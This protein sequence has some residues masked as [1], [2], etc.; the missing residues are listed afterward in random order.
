[1]A[2][3]LLSLP[4]ATPL[5]N[6]S[7]L[8]YSNI[9]ASVGLALAYYVLAR[10]GLQFQLAGSHATPVW[11][12]SG[13]ALAAILL[14]DS[15]SEDTLRHLH[16]FLKARDTLAPALP[17]QVLLSADGAEN[18]ESKASADPATIGKALG[19]PASDVSSG[20]I[21]DQ[22]LRL[23]LLDRLLQQARVVD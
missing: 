16:A 9:G 4:F 14:M 22:T 12:P 3:P 15:A 21:Q 7:H 5:R 17:V 11:P 8:V 10:I 2:L 23:T 13:L 6:G 19:L 1:M 20:H 18:G